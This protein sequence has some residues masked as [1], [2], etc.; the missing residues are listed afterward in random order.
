MDGGVVWKFC[1]TE[2]LTCGFSFLVYTLEEVI[3][4]TLILFLCFT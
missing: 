1:I 4:S 2:V 3:K